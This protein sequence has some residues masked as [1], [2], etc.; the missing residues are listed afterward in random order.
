[1]R[2]GG[3]FHRVPTFLHAISG[4]PWWVFRPEYR[5]AHSFRFTFYRRLLQETS[6]YVRESRRYRSRI[7]LQCPWMDY[8]SFS[9]SILRLIGFG[10]FALC[11]L[12]LS[13]IATAAVGLRQG[14]RK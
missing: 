14:L 8:R 9:G 3:L 10:H 2:I 13:L 4:K 6:P 7:D 1:M 12:P 5:S 11:G